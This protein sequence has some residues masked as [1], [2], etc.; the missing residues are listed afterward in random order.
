[1]KKTGLLVS[2]LFLAFGVAFADPVTLTFTGLQDQE[3]ILNYYNGGFGDAGSGPGPNYGIVFGSNSFAL[4]SDQV[5][6]SGN[7]SNVPPPGSTTVAFF[8]SGGGDTM[9]VA[10]G[11]TT[12]FSFYYASPS[13]DGT[14]NVYSGL[15]GTG[16]LLQTISLTANGTGCDKSGDTF[17]CWTEAG[18]TFAGTAESVVFSG[19]AD[20]IAFAD[21]TLGSSTVETGPPIPPSEV[22]EPNSLLLLG[23]GVVSVAGVL[24]RRLAA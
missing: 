7:F 1:M 19:A 8:V 3:A 14:V 23:T 15:D 12:G 2:F 11:F 13:I 24:R 18:A 20:E 4:I 9:N 17:D 10:A 5:G 22:P 6:G 21:V 16:F